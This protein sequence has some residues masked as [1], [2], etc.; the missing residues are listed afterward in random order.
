MTQYVGCDHARELLDGL[1]D[2]ELSMTDQLAV[3]SHLR[4]C[5][6][7]AL[8]VED[9]RLIGTSLRVG[10]PLHEAG[11]H[12]DSTVAAINEA[13]LMRV[14]AERDQSLG[15]RV[16][17]MFADMRL[18]WPAVGAS[19]AVMVCVGLAFSVLQAASEQRPQSLAALIATLANPG[20]EGNPVRPADNGVSIP[21]ML[22]G[23]T[24]A[25]EDIPEDE[26]IFTFRTVVSRDGRIAA[27]EL[28]LSNAVDTTG[29]RRS[30]EHVGHEQAIAE[31]VRQQRFAPAQTP[32]GRAVAVDMVWMIAK[33]TA[34]AGPGVE[35][36]VPAAPPHAQ[37]VPEPAIVSPA[38]PVIDQRSSI[39]L[40]SATV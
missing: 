5:R 13:V 24:I 11:P 20:S 31:A 19:A 39:G 26:A 30:A 7:C 12:A 33:T 16:R 15:V 3:E 4:W 18:F 22:V 40:P 8:R 10:S 27:F 6:T 34:V 21:R 29:H 25:L 1:I 28:L 2:N 23:G 37:D 32:L 9:M 38:G 17:E 14:R 36:D 35:F